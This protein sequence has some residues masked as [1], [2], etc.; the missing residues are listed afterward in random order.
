MQGTQKAAPMISALK[1]TLSPVELE[2]LSGNMWTS[3]KLFP[4][5]QNP[6]GAND[7][8]VRKWPKRVFGTRYMTSAISAQKS[9]FLMILWWCIIN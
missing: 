7:A 4:N 8:R 1:I 6:Q 2:R 9:R 3:S 5:V